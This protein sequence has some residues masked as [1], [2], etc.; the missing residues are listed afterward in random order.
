MA[1]PVQRQ[2]SRTPA[3]FPNSLSVLGKHGSGH[4]ADPRTW[5]SQTGVLCHASPLR[6]YCFS[7]EDSQGPWGL[8]FPSLGCRP[9]GWQESSPRRRTPN[10]SSFGVSLGIGIVATFYSDATASAL[11]CCFMSRLPTGSLRPYLKNTAHADREFCA[12]V[13]RARMLTCVCV[14]GLVD[15]DGI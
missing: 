5:D 14:F 9:C 15:E 3:R 6:S 10:H 7:R 1:G 8:P 12:P 2:Q 4:P 11:L 13:R